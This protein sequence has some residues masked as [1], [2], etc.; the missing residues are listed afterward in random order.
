MK[1]RN[2]LFFV[3]SQMIKYA[4]DYLLPPKNTHSTMRNQPQL[5]DKMNVLL[6]MCLRAGKR[7]YRGLARK[8]IV[9]EMRM[10]AQVCDLGE[11]LVSQASS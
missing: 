8:R 7:S 11:L 10:M 5:Q 9:G 1:I 6:G 3:L 4:K 2:T